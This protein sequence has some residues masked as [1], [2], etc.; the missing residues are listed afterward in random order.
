MTTPLR[1]DLY[2]APAI[3]T[4]S[5]LPDGTT[6]HWQPTVV[7]LISG[8]TT[9]V[10]I[11]TLFTDTQ[12]IALADWIDAT[13]GPAHK[14]LTTIYITHG[15]GD[16]WFNLS[17]LL[18]RFPGVRVLATRAAIDHMRTQQS[19]EMRGFWQTTFPGQ[20]GEDAFEILATPLPDDDKTFTLEGHTFE[21]VDAGHSDTDA[22]TFLHV[23]ALRLVVAGD[24][25]YNDVHMWMAETLDDAGREAWVAALDRIE[26]CE[27]A[28][29]VGSHHR[30]GGVDGVWNV[31]ASREY[32]RTFGRLVGES[33]G[34]EELYEKAVQAYPGREGRLVLW[35][36]CKAA[37][38]QGRGV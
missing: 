30:L 25:V 21:A 35:L 37:F 15:H 5:L 13:L 10:L 4:S 6:G 2:N 17:Y 26:A 14:T 20:I 29:V 38:V 9:A 7:T 16:H 33:G 31:E 18:T 11:D 34:A 36:G 32:V 24:I 19:A 8:A 23:P 28:V 1:A 27:P 3:P 22:T 12:G